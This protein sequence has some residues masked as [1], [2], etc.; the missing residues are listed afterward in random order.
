MSASPPFVIH[1]LVPLRTQ[2]S[3]SSTAVVRTPAA[4]DPAFASVSANAAIVP[5]AMRGR[6]FFFCSSLPQSRIG[7]V[8]RA[9][10]K[11]E[12]AMPAQYFES[13]S[14][15]TTMSIVPPPMPPYAS[16]LKRPK[17]PASAKSFTMSVG[18]IP[19]S[20]YFARTGRIFFS[21]ISRQVFLISS[22]SSVSPRS[23]GFSMALRVRF[24]VFVV[25]V[26]RMLPQFRANRSARVLNAR[27]LFFAGGL[28]TPRFSGMIPVRRVALY[29][30]GN[31]RP[32]KNNTQQSRQP[33]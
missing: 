1:C 23:S 14:T 11:S 9:V 7:R 20:S 6:Y 13:S 26:R 22:C 28:T 4:S 16:G 12:S 24:R 5:S 31:R 19:S 21:P 27:S 32:A 33:T 25:A 15:A 29:P 3:P 2:A 8:P 30:F 18:K 10:P 17:S